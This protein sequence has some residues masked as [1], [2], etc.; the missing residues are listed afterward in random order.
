VGGNADTAR[1]RE[2]YYK[3]YHPVL[4]LIETVTITSPPGFKGVTQNIDIDFPFVIPAADALPSTGYV[5]HSLVAALH[6]FFA[7]DTFEAGAIMAVNLG[8]D[9]D[10][11]G[12]IYAGLAGCWYASLE[13][14]EAS[15]PSTARHLF[16]SKKVLEW[17][18]GLFRRDLVE[19][20][21][22]E[23]ARYERSL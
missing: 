21:A 17:K 10:T 8:N 14:G 22:E 13:E 7:T 2:A 19:E 3:R 9:A 23:L 11:V 12:A 15:K 1:Q 18:A 5:L 16:W 6:C 20:V 4:R